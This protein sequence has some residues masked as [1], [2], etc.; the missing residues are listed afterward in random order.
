MGPFLA[1]EAIK[2]AVAP[3]AGMSALPTFPPS[4]NVFYINGKY[5]LMVA[6]AWCSYCGLLWLLQL[7]Q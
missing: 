2:A 5:A 7:L 3:F 6:V 4:S 1:V